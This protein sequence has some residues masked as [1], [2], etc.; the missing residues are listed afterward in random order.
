MLTP[1][2]GHCPT[3]SPGWDF[4]GFYRLS[5]HALE[6]IAQR[7]ICPLDVAIALGGRRVITAHDHVLYYDRT[8]RTVAVVDPG[9]AVIIT[10]YR[11][12][13]HDVKRELSR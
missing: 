11:L 3:K 4:V 8:S 6:M 5:G 7:E 10:V 9:D 12:K 13:K 1:I 2:P